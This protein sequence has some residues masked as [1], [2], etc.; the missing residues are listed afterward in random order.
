SLS[1]S[2][3]SFPAATVRMIMPK[4]SGFIDDSKRVNRFLSALSVIFLEI[5]TVL[6]NGTNMIYLPAI[7]NSQDNRGPLVEIGSF[8]TCTISCWF[9]VSTWLSFPSL[10]ISGSS[11]NFESLSTAFLLLSANL[12]NLFKDLT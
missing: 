4:F 11:L 10:S 8:T 7:D 12:V 2:A 9:L 1:S 5:L 6:E 3:T